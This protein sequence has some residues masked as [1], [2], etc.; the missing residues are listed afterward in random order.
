MCPNWSGS[1]LRGLSDV[2]LFE[3]FEDRGCSPR[4]VGARLLQAP[5]LAAQGRAAQLLLRGM[6]K[7]GLGLG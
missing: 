7:G 1:R 3:L 6:G 4:L 5:L 2:F